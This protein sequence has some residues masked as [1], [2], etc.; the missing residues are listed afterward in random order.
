MGLKI[1]AKCA[2]LFM[3]E[4]IALAAQAI[5]KKWKTIPSM[6]GGQIYVKGQQA[7]IDEP[8]LR[9]YGIANIPEGL[10]PTFH[11]SDERYLWIGNADSTSLV[12]LE[13]EED[14]AALGSYTRKPKK[15]PVFTTVSVTA[16]IYRMRLLD[17]PAALFVTSDGVVHRL[18]T[19]VQDGFAHER[20]PQALTGYYDQNGDYVEPTPPSSLAPFD[21]K[22]YLAATD[23]AVCCLRLDIYSDGETVST[24]WSSGAVVYEAVASFSRADANGVETRYVTPLTRGITV[25]IGTLYIM[26]DFFAYNASLVAIPLASGT[27]TSPRRITD[28]YNGRID[29][30]TLRYTE[31]SPALGIQD[32][33]T[34]LSGLGGTM[35]LWYNSNDSGASGSGTLYGVSNGAPAVIDTAAGMAALAGGSVCAY[36]DFNASAGV[37]YRT[38]AGTVLSTVVNTPSGITHVRMIGTP[39]GQ[40]LFVDANNDRILAAYG[41]TLDRYDVLVG[42]PIHTVPYIWSVSLVGTRTALFYSGGGQGLFS[43]DGGVAWTA[44]DSVYHELNNASSALSCGAAS[45]E[46]FDL[47]AY[48]YSSHPNM[49]ARTLFYRDSVLVGQRDRVIDLSNPY[50]WPVSL[51]FSYGLVFETGSTYIAGVKHMAT[52]P[53]GSKLYRVECDE[54]KYVLVHTDGTWGLFSLPPELQYA[55]ELRMF[56]DTVVYGLVATTTGPIKQY[57]VEWYNGTVRTFPPGGVCNLSADGAGMA[58][59]H[60]RSVGAPSFLSIFK[61]GTELYRGAESATGA[62]EN[63][64]SAVVTPETAIVEDYIGVY[65]E[66]GFSEI[67]ATHT[68]YGDGESYRLQLPAGLVLYDIQQVVK[69]SAAMTVLKTRRRTDGAFTPVYIWLSGRSLRL[70]V[71]DTPPPDEI[72]SAAPVGVDNLQVVCFAAGNSTDVYRLS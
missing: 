36:A 52:S 62:T 5:R 4:N 19:T 48:S 33:I 51:S 50:G 6:F 31:L 25:F 14:P 67:R 32:Y 63:Y 71:Y 17:K 56:S 24:P 20:A 18:T 57:L 72:V 34:V 54:W 23:T 53:S 27:E 70:V 10:V 38:H 21:T 8:A 3:R 69:A 44:V 13:Y 26:Y 7:L 12:I 46:G 42:R 40:S 45:Y 43:V 2:K 55:A 59:V 61:G 66:D 64:I 37:L 9:G 68:V 39:T 35:F 47:I 22:T 15:T 49:R 58:Y 60:Y 65:G 41:V 1:I 28:I 11:Y 16:N 29:P 30:V